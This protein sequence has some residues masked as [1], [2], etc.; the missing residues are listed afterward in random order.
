MLLI[1]LLLNIHMVLL[2]K[3]ILNVFY[4]SKIKIMKIQ[5]LSENLKNWELKLFLFMAM[6]KINDIK[7]C[8]H[9]ILE[10]VK[11]VIVYWNV[12]HFNYQLLL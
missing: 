5:N 3:V 6:I 1:N 11:M 4:H 12:L 8:V 2:I 10:H 7:Q 9:L